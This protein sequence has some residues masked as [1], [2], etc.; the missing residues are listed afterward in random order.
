[1]AFRS[2]QLRGSSLGAHMATAT[3]GRAPEPCRHCEK[4]GCPCGQDEAAKAVE[5][6]RAL[7]M[8]SGTAYAEREA[9]DFTRSIP[10][11]SLTRPGMLGLAMAAES[12][13]S[14]YRL[15]RRTVEVEACLAVEQAARAAA[16]KMP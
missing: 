3:V 11:G 2:F 10:T 16:A 12:L 8:P 4:L 9:R 6:A 15:G 13:A 14:H 1:M 7:P 5:M